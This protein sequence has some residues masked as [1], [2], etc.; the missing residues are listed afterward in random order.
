MNNPYQIVTEHEGNYE[1]FFD[2]YLFFKIFR[3]IWEEFEDKST[4]TK[5]IKFI[6]YGFSLQSTMITVNGDRRKE[7]HAI[8]DHL[9]IDKKRYREVVLLE[10]TVVMECCRKWMDFQDS[11]Q[12]EYLLTLKQSYIQQQAASISPLRKSDGVAIDFDQKH[13]CIEHMRELNQWI[14]EA[15]QELI[16]NNPKLKE[17][18]KIAGVDNTRNNKRNKG[19]EAFLKEHENGNN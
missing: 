17:S 15:E 19:M 16:Q 2:L 13:K 4:A 9:E 10:D 8:F 18:Y 6:V 1:N 5:I 3:P 11:S 14:K 12:L 7:L